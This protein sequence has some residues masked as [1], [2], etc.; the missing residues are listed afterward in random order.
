MA[1]DQTITILIADDEPDILELMVEEFEDNGFEVVSASCGDE[2]AAIIKDTGTNIQVVLSDFKMPNGS[3]MVILEEVL[4]MDESNRPDFFFVSGQ[5]DIPVQECLD[6]GA[7]KFFTKP[8]DIDEL[9]S[10]INSLLKK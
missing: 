7:K 4:Q 3:G 10:D 2:G 8:F 5:A 1:D 6:K 9:I